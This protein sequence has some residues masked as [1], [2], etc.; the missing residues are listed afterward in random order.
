MSPNRLYLSIKQHVGKKTQEN[1]DGMLAG[2]KTPN[3]NNQNLDPG[4]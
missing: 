4:T 2:T 1:Q 3:N